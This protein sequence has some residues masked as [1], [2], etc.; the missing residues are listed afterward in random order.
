MSVID[1]LEW[2]LDK[3]YSQDCG[4]FDDINTL[5]KTLEESTLELIRLGRVAEQV[6]KDI[7]YSSGS[8]IEDTAYRVRDDLSEALRELVVVV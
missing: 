2:L 1:D 7:N 5:I 4:I 3:R 8:T 6:A